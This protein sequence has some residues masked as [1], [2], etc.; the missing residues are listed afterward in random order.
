MQQE[1]ISVKLQVKPY[2]GYTGT[3]EI[4]K[5]H[6]PEEPVIDGLFSDLV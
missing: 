3:N 4:L 5:P 6:H 1:M 2:L